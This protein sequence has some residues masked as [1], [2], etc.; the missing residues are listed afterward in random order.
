MN[1]P[2]LLDVPACSGWTE[3]D[4]AMYNSMP[5]YLAKMMVERRKTFT[6]WAKFVKKRKWVPNEGDTLKGVITEPSP[7]RRQFAYPNLLK[8]VPKKDVMGVKERTVQ[9]NVYRQRF[10]SHGLN[11]YPSFNDFLD[12]VDDNATDIMEKIERYEDIFIRTNIWHMSPFMFLAQP[13]KMVVVN[14][15]PWLGVGTFDTA[16]DG[17][18]TA[19]LLAQLGNVTSHLTLPALH[20]AFS[21]MDTDFRIPFFKG[22]DMPTEDKILDGKYCLSTSNETYSQFT[23]DP[24]LQQHKNCDLDVVNDSFKGS[25]FGMITSKLEDLPM[26]FKNDATFPEPEIVQ[27]NGENE[28]ECLPN[29]VYAT[30]DENGSPYEVS[31]LIG[32]PGHESIQ[33]GPPPSAFTGDSPPHNFPKMEWNGRVIATK[34]KLVPCIDASTG[35]TVYETNVYGEWLWFIAQVALGIVAKQRR[36]IFPIVH[37]RKRGV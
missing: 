12:H 21:K 34:Q 25:I 16:N 8:N 3:V 9:A 17:K 18:T 15:P 20:D 24:Y 5:F 33:V 31:Y 22:S 4:R 1:M 2:N 13:N 37:K 14:T 28:G 32:A 6:H 10:E 29:P 19:L 11:F 26:R 23:F 30:I 27:D 7:H 35:L 36:N